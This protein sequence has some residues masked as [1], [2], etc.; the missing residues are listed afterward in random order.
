MIV[1]GSDTT[2]TALANALA[3]LLANPEMYEKLR[4]ELSQIIPKDVDIPDAGALI[5]CEYLNAVMC[6]ACTSS[7]FGLGD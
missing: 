6:A 3:N 5:E 2:G 7:S 1:A 4:A